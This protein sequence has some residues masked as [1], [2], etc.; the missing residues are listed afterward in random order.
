MDLD[1][2]RNAKAEAFQEAFGFREVAGAMSLEEVGPLFTSTPGTAPHDEIV[3]GRETRRRDPRDLIALGVLRPSGHN[4]NPSE[5]RVGIF[6]QQKR[7]IQYEIVQ[8]VQQISRGECRVIVTGPVQRHAAALPRLTRPLTVGAS[9]GHYRVT[10]GTLAC[11]VTKREGGGLGML[12]NNHVFADT[13]RGAPGDK[14]LQPARRDGGRANDRAFHVGTLHKFVPIDFASGA[15]NYVDCAFAH[16]LDGLEI[17]PTTITDP[18]TPANSWRIGA[19]DSVVYDFLPVKKVGRTTDLT[20]GLV[21]AIE[22]DN[23]TVNMRPGAPA[24]VARFDRQIA[25]SGNGGAFSK[26]G[27]SGS[28]VFTDDGRPIGLLFAGTERGGAHDLGLTYANPIGLVL[29]ALGVDIY[30]G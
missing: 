1:G 23:V 6:V 13:N 30:T 22:V 28:M 24:H 27:D 7:L 10:A 17:E 11:F 2:A 3:R 25:I 21:E 5:L 15:V 19:V 29:D 8:S 12:S 20:E 26:G 14:I 9:V 18:G 16:L 4:R